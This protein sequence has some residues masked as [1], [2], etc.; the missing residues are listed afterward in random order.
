MRPATIGW[1]TAAT[2]FLALLSIRLPGIGVYVSV[3]LAASAG[4]GAWTT[5]QGERVKLGPVRPVGAE[6]DP[7]L[8]LEPGQ[9]HA[10]KKAVLVG[11]AT[12][13]VQLGRVQAHGRKELDAA[14]WAR[15]SRLEPG[16]RFGG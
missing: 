13:P 10:G 15:G 14:D 2:L 7:P 12:S 16:A 5:L 11:T 8:D 4:A 1:F 3:L 9:L 6:Q